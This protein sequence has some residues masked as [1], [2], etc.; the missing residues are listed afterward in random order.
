M[1]NSLV[2][3]QHYIPQMYLKNFC[4]DDGKK[5]FEYN[6]YIKEI[7]YVSISEICKEQYL[8]EFKIRKKDFFIK[9]NEN[10]FEK[11]LS[12]IES[13]D[14]DLLRKIL[15]VVEKSKDYVF[16][17]KDERESLLGFIMLML[18]RNPAVKDALPEALKLSTGIEKL[19]EEEIQFAWLFTMSNIDKFGNDIESS[20]ITFLKTTEA[21]PF[22]TSS[23]PMYFEGVP[24][25]KNFYMPIS[26]KVALTLEVPPN[27][28]IRTDRCNVRLLSVNE[29][30]AYNSL[31]LSRIDSIICSS[32]EQL[33]KHI[34][35]MDQCDKI[36]EN[37]YYR[38][39][40]E[41]IKKMDK[42][43]IEKLA[44][45]II[46]YQI[47]LGNEIYKLTYQRLIESGKTDK[48]ALKMMASI[49]GE[50][51]LKAVDNN[52][53]VDEERMKH[54]FSKLY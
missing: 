12:Q 42:E 54:L 13:F 31:L 41:M 32:K 45:K 19:G 33:E 38:I 18:L 43:S 27:K 22:I 21:D 24:I 17:S 11:L 47:E 9:G 5:C 52:M 44:I 34:M 36:K 28:L 25:Q 48:K 10:K 50:E 35:L 39:N 30:D 23:F 14:A 16:L 51:L 3:Q 49:V 26:S 7:R 20:Q 40:V 8:Y 46:E 15:S 6:P 37:P 53:R 4:T 29:V 2:K 1:S